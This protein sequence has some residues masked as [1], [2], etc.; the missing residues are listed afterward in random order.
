MNKQLILCMIDH[1]TLIGQNFSTEKQRQVE[2][3]DEVFGC[4]RSNSLRRSE[5]AENEPMQLLKK[6]KVV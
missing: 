3:R 6:Q 2:D 5:K 4:D 1:L